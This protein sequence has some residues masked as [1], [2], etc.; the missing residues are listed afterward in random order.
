MKR[1]V[2]RPRIHKG[3]HHTIIVRKGT[4]DLMSAY[5]KEQSERSGIEVKMVDIADVAI[6]AIIRHENFF[7]FAIDSK[8]NK[9]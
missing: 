4:Y 9:D 5:Q 3:G 2:G 8:N 1:K 6:K 7:Q